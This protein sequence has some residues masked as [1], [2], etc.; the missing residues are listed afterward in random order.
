MKSNKEVTLIIKTFIRIDCVVRLLKSIKRYANGYP[1]IICDDGI[2]KEKNKEYII[3]KFTDMDIEYICAEEDIGL[4]AGRNLLIDHVKT[5]YFLL[6]DDDFVFFKKTDLEIAKK[7]LQD[8]ELDILGGLCLHAN[9][10]EFGS[11]TEKIN[12]IVRKIR[13]TFKI[14]RKVGYNGKIEREN[15]NINIYLKKMNYNSDK[16][17]DT[18]ICE[19]FFIA[20]TEKVKKVRWHDKL[21]LNEHED[22]FIRAK[23][24]NLKIGVTAAFQVYHYPEQDAKFKIHRQKNYYEEV[25]KNN[26]LEN[27]LIY[28][29]AVGVIQHYQMINDKLVMKQSYTKNLLG[30]MKKVYYKL[31]K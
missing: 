13:T 6:C 4:S 30:I 8:N 14:Y 20:D 27:L 24:A 21:K 18:D 11:K 10:I 7:L 28:R 31:K 16:I 29:S 26:N 25:M 22:F 3:S 1:I 19:N 5:K 23:E 2:D 17:E 15:K 12:L 9:R